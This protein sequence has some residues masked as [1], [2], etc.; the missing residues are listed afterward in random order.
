VCKCV[1]YCCHQ[2][3]TQ[4]QLTNISYHHAN[5]LLGL[6]TN[7][8][9]LTIFHCTLY[10][11]QYYVSIY[12]QL[13]TLGCKWQ[14]KIFWTNRPNGSSHFQNLICPF[15]LMGYAVVQLVEV[16]AGRPQVGFPM[17]SLE[18]F[19]DHILLATLWPWDRISL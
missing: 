10:K 15:F 3:T 1:L 4:L 11:R 19:I 17:W 8:V 14:D 18:F 6:G 9:I 13:Y 5:S 2:V 12:F 7:I 16:Q